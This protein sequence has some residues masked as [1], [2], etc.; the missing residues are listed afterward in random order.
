MINKNT[1]ADLI[2]ATEKL[3]IK[4]NVVI[5]NFKIEKESAAYNACSF[6]INKKNIL[7]REAKITPTK[8]GQF[9]TIWKRNEFGITEPYNVNDTIDLVVIGCRH[10][11][12]FGQFVFP[13][14][15]LG[16][17]KIFTKNS[18]EG[19]RG[20][21]VY[22]PWDIATNKHA[23]QTQA[24]QLEYFLEMRGIVDLERAKRLYGI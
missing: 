23:L 18:I 21:R 3:Y 7:Y 20:I 10:N 17:R 19:K 15:I 12:H 22:P 9:V 14:N 1:S 11:E 2:I 16:E 8:I 13:K 5:A 24:S 6:E 4:I